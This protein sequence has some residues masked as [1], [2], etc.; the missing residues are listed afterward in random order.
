MGFIHPYQR[1]GH[2]VIDFETLLP[3]FV[4]IT[5]GKG[6]DN[7]IAKKLRFSPG[8]IVVADRIYSDTELLNLWYRRDILFVVRG[9]GNLL[10]ESIKERELPNKSAQDILIDKEVELTGVEMADKYPRKIRCIAICIR[11]AM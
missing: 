5:D 3:E 7:T 11:M 8:T 6:A 9:K 1:G 10:F 2:T 4:C